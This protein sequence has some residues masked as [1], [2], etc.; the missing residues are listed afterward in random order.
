VQLFFRASHVKLWVVFYPR[1]IQR[2]VV[3]HEVEQQL[4]S[5]PVQPIAEPIK[6]LF[7]PE[8]GVYFVIGDREAGT[9]DIVF[10]KIWENLL[11]LS[12]PPAILTRHP[13]ASWSRLPNTEK[14]NPVKARA[15]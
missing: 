11:K 3:G 4:H 1:V 8:V 10:L 15:R 5:A 9:A 13:L 12:P 6:S 14:P 7:S 2:C